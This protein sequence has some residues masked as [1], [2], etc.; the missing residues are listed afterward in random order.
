MKTKE[1]Q[2]NKAVHPNCMPK[3]ISIDWNDRIAYHLLQG[4]DQISCHENFTYYN[5]TV[6][7]TGMIKIITFLNF[8]FKLQMQSK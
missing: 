6:E 1:N 3:K 7:G 4:F 2:L 5:L 8:I